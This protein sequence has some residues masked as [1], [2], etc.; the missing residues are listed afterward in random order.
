MQIFVEEKKSSK[1]K[2]ATA[3]LFKEILATK[4]T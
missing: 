1:H 3:L 2:L 4:N